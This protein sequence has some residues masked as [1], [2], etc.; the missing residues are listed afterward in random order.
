MNY[1][2]A[3]HA[4]NFADVFKHIVLMRVIE[5]LKG[6]D[7]AFR[8]IDTHAGPGLYDLGGEEAGKTGEWHEGIARLL[9]APP[10]GEAGALI[11][12][13]LDLAGSGEFMG[14]N[15]Y[16]GSPLI[17]RH[18]L[19]RQDRLTAIELHPSD[20]ERLKALFEGDHQV[21]VI[22]LDGWL[23]PGAQLPPKEKRGLVLIDPPFEQ[24][25]EFDRLAEALE[26]G[27]KRWPGGVF[28]AWYPVKN[29]AQVEA[30]RARLRT[31]PVRDAVDFTIMVADTEPGAEPSFDGCGIVA[32][33]APWTLAGE[34]RT[35]MTAIA[36][37]L[38]RAGKGRFSIERLTAE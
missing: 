24:P 37:V 11:R 22:H 12:P 33:N 13:Y 10:G 9:A 27:W 4:G 7:K 6:K 23:A 30:F 20:A 3:Y 21:R 14:A 38:A 29:R 35:I 25:G 15:R 32:V 1:R 36:P 19:R 17:A 16:P 8:V 31:G 18:L 2:H 28:L 5:Y 34:M 26:T